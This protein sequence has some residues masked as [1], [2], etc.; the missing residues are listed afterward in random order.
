MLADSA[1][2]DVA[3]HVT[4][5]VSVGTCALALLDSVLRSGASPSSLSVDVVHS[6]ISE[7]F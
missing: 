3:T 4:V 1:V 7:Y 2:R 5:H 6:L